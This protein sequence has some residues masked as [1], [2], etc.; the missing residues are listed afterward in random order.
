MAIFL[1]FFT[2]GIFLVHKINLV[3]ADLGRHLRNGEF[4][5][6]NPSLLFRNFYSH[7]YLNF[8]RESK[9]TTGD[10]SALFYFQSAR[11]YSLGTKFFSLQN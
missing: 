7:T 10:F 8:N 3:T 5:F 2:Y 4:L 11:R 6:Q 9:N 1:L